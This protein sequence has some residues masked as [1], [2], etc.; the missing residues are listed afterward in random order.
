MAGE[1]ENTTLTARMAKTYPKALERE[2][3]G[4]AQLA[5]SSDC[6]PRVVRGITS[7]TGSRGIMMTPT[8]TL[9]IQ[10]QMAGFR[11]FSVAEYHKLIE[12]GVLTE[13]DNLELLEGYLV[14]KMSRKP[15]H[16]ATLQLL[17]HA[18]LPVLPPGWCFRVQS[19][20]TL[21]DSEP[22]PDFAI[23]RGNARTYATRHPRPADIGLL[24]EV[25]DSTLD[26]D[27]TDKGR[28]YARAGIPCY[29][30]VNLVDRQVEAF[31]SP[32]GPTAAPAFAQRTC[33]RVGDSVPLQLDGSAIGTVAVQDMLP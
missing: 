12:I 9:P 29:W 28:I 25:A 23:A 20:I 32:S 16:D 2:G 17:L 1:T 22:E 11:R 13:D 24:I 3:G 18:L 10:G 14:H 15:P 4:S 31:T 5:V 30:I 33:Y 6:G 7:Y 27:R 26:G 19:A 21:A 8:A